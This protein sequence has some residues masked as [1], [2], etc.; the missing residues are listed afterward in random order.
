MLQRLCP[1]TFAFFVPVPQRLSAVLLTFSLQL[2]QLKNKILREAKPLRFFCVATFL[3]A[4]EA[5]SVE[6]G[7]AEADF[8]GKA[9]LF[10][11]VLSWNRFHNLPAKCSIRQ[12]RQS[13]CRKCS[14][15]PKEPATVGA[16]DQ[17][18]KLLTTPVVKLVLLLKKNN[19]AAWSAFLLL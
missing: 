1:C 12:S 8:Q 11:S 5:S 4:S 9:S 3:K 14:K 6:T 2:L 19:T 15:K 10:Y 13:F 16:N 18:T 17:P 7:S